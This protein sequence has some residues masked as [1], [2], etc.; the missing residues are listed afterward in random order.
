MH[1]NFESNGKCNAITFFGGGPLLWFCTFAWFWG[2]D[3]ARY[4]QDTTF[5]TKNQPK[6]WVEQEKPLIL[7]KQHVFYNFYIKEK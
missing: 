5:G 7:A 2:H 4:I 6:K 3:F 1:Y